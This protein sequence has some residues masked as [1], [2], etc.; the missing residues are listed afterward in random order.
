MKAGNTKAIREWIVEAVPK[1]GMTLDELEQK[2]KELG[3]KVIE[4]RANS[5]LM[6]HIK[7]EVT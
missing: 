3:N 1:D 4:R 2:M 5:L 7:Q 6:I